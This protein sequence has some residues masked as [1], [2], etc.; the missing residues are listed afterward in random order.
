MRRLPPLNAIR[1]FEAAARHSSFMKAAQEL[2]VTHGAVWR[3]VEQLEEWFGAPL[4]RRV[5]RRIYLTEDGEQFLAAAGP[6]LDRLESA[7]AAVLGRRQA[8]SV[9]VNAA[10]TLSTHW[11]IPRLPR[12]YESHPGVQIRLATSLSLSDADLSGG[13]YDVVI[14]RAA[15]PVPSMRWTKL[16]APMRV[17]LCV[18]QPDAGHDASGDL[19]GRTLIHATD[20]P[21]Y[22]AQVLDH[23]GLKADRV[24]GRLYYDQL[25]FAVEAAMQGLGCAVV[26]G[27]MLVDDI[28]A[29]RLVLPFGNRIVVP[30]SDYAVGTLRQG[31][32]AV[33]GFIDWLQGEGAASEKTLRSIMDAC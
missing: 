1:M 31:N 17:P 32:D 6:A 23:F 10:L 5:G 28:E 22:W 3:Q 33:D 7:A 16:F 27:T 30:S 11:L 29:G 25:Y 20:A 24:A 14:C 21:D 18:A 9:T 15:R 8:R 26:P 2:H 13:T 4:F 19:A 12:F